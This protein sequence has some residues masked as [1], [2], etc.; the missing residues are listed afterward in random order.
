MQ[1]YTSQQIQDAC[2]LAMFRRLIT[3]T[4]PKGI[5]SIV[6]DTWDFWK[7][8]T[9]YTVA[10][11]DDILNRGDDALGM[12]KVVFRPDSGCPVDI[13]C[14]ESISFPDKE[15]FIDYVMN[16]KDEGESAYGLINGTH[17]LCTK[18]RGKKFFE[19]V[20][21]EV[22]EVTP[23]MKGAVECLYEIFGGTETELGY[24]QL[25][26][27]VGLIYGDSITL[28]RADEILSRLQKKGFASGNV[29]LGIGSYSYQYLTRDTFGFAMK[30]TYGEVDG[31][32]REIFKLPKTGDGTKNSAKGL[33]KVVTNDDWEYELIDSVSLEEEL[34]DNELQV[35]FSNGEFFN[36]TSLEDIRSRTK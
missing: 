31:E 3:E 17:Y 29:V 19:P 25:H 22:T 35:I 36:E 18:T 7:V 14:G 16:N 10:L 24:K 30:A 20:I 9:E 15:T 27:K 26:S 1:K 23:E 11:K 33:L 12:S 32:G 4:Y 13:L 8:L 6:S 28:E 21:T 5:V 34:V 2:E